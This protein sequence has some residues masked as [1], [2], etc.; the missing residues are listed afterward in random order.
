MYPIVILLAS[1]FSAAFAAE[2]SFPPQVARRHGLFKRQEY[3]R[4]DNIKWSYYD[5]EQSGNPGACG[6]HHKNSEYFVAMNRDQFRD[7]YCFKSITLERNGRTAQ[8]Q[9]VDR[10]GSGCPY[11][12]VDLSLA[13]ADYFGIRG[14]GVVYDGSWSIG[15]KPAPPP[16]TTTPEPEPT[17]TPTPDPVAPSTTTTRARSS[18]ASYSASSVRSASSGTGPRPS[19][20][21]GSTDDEPS[22]ALVAMGQLALAYGNI[23]V[24]NGRAPQ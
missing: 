11:G 5:F 22:G 12:G 18:S 20:A 19:D 6:Q 21:A 4:E 7:S 16:P 1:A 15:S 10:C 8:A 9:V 24:L 3:H 2:H 17:P 14:D 13:L 23:I